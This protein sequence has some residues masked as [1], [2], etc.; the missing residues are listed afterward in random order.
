VPF[1]DLEEG[2]ADLFSSVQLD[3]ARLLSL[4]PSERVDSDP[5]THLGIRSSGGW[6]AWRLA[7]PEKNKSAKAEWQRLNRERVRESNR[8]TK[9]RRTMLRRLSSVAPS[10]DNNLILHHETRRPMRP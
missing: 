7:N 3:P 10:N 1:E 6:E 5:D 8:L 4:R 9:R 2:I